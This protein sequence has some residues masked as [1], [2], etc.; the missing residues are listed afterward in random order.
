[1]LK[2]T[3]SKKFYVSTIFPAL[4]VQPVG[5]PAGAVGDGLQP[6]AVPMVPLSTH[7]GGFGQPARWT[8]AA[9]G[10][11]ALQHYHQLGDIVLF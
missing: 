7:T 9:Y 2:T 3:E 6:V 5:D 11:A 8:G 10:Q 4:W 1:M